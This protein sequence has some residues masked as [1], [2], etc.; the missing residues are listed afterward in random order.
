MAD[1]I[2]EYLPS[3]FE[4]LFMIGTRIFLIKIPVKIENKTIERFQ[5]NGGVV[6]D[7]LIKKSFTRRKE[8]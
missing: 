2:T 4:Y 8:N 7:K 1:R 6:L 3:W 5:I